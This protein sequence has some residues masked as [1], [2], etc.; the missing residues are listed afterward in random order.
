MILG[1]FH[2]AHAGFAELR[3]PRFQA[4]PSHFRVFSRVAKTATRLSV[5]RVAK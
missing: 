1:A 3:P 2:R 5:F 4:L